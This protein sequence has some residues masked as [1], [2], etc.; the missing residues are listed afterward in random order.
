ME[1]IFQ[2]ALFDDKN[3]IKR[4]EAIAKEVEERFNK[5]PLKWYDTCTKC[6]WK[7]RGIANPMDGTFTCIR[8]LVKN[9]VERRFKEA[10]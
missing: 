6:G 10:R 1:A 5:N 9:E 2:Q 8:C 4:I 3:D 7:G